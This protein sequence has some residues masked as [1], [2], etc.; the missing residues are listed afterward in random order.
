MLSSSNSK[1][2]LFSSRKLLQ[3]EALRSAKHNLLKGKPEEL[4][5][6][7]NMDE[8]ARLYTIENE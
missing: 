5:M 7:R 2:E 1:L 8:N 6:F 3:N 4:V